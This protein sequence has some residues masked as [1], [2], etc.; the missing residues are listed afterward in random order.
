MKSLVRKIMKISK[1]S[2]LIVFLLLCAGGLIFSGTAG[3]Q[4]GSYTLSM[5]PRYYPEKIKAMIVPLAE[6]LSQKTGDKFV[7]VLTDDFAD[8]ATRVRSGQISIG[9][10][11]PVV[12]TQVAGA[13]EVLA[14]ALKGEGED[15]FRG[16]IIT[17]KDSDIHG[18]SD[19][20][21]KRVMIVGRTSA[22]GFL[23]QK[24]SLVQNGIDVDKDCEIEE[25]SAN[26]QENVIIAVSIGDV[27]AGFI[28]ESALHTAD[29]YIPPGS[30]TVMAPCAW[31]PN[32]ALSVN[33]T[34][35]ASVKAGIRSALLE[36]ADGHAVLKAMHVNG[37]RAASDADYDTL[38]HLK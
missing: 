4:G 17:R 36:L 32:W 3:A 9:Y 29:S 15:R 12:Y 19:L 5:L 28:R 26:K 24:L 18:F 14:M 11:N 38:R 6:Y 20:R 35:P 34:L 31:L 27:D 7:P 21:H 22:G 2:P 13:H 23:S 33:S 30:I 25:A 16:I 37:F 8:Y 1:I 10:E